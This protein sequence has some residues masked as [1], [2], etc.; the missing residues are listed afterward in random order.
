[1]RR[2][3]IAD[4]HGNLVALNAVLDDC[5]KQCV[6]EIV[7]LGD[8]VGFGPDPL[9]CVDLVMQCCKWSLMGD[10]EARVF[11]KD[12][13]ANLNPVARAAV[14]REYKL[15]APHWFSG[16]TV[17]QRWSWLQELQP[18]KTL[19]NIQYVHGSPRDPLMECVMREDFFEGGNNVAKQIMASF[20]GIC[21]GAHTHR[22]GVVSSNFQWFRPSELDNSRYTI[23]E[24]MKTLIC[25]GSVGQPRDGDPRSCY[26]IWDGEGQTVEF[27]RV[28]YDFAATKERFLKVPELPEMLYLRLEKGI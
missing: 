3:L 14:E 24:R 20:D 4:I 19:N 12:I 9:E 8:I 17:R 1:M 25:I 10:H 28:A 13:A 27:R 11:N 26:V 6:D 16:R 23:F 21:F 5:A 18:A 2:A 15:F 7:C 22:P